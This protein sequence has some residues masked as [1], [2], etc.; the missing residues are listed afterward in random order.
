MTIPV[1]CVVL[2]GGPG[3]LHV[4]DQFE[5]SYFFL[6]LFILTNYFVSRLDHV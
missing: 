3:T 1:V 5:A 2:D 4:R 6:P